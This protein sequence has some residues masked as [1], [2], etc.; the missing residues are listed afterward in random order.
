[1]Q[2]PSDMDTYLSLC[3]LPPAPSCPLSL[4]LCPGYCV[5]P[6]DSI[7]CLSPDR[8]LAK[9]DSVK[10]KYIFAVRGAGEKNQNICKN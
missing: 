7:L 5:P 1:M 2:S 3:P 8:K 10:E 9:L 4:A 6:L